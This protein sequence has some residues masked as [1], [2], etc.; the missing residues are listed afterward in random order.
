MDTKFCGTCGTYKTTEGMQE[1][2]AIVTRGSS[3]VIGYRDYVL[4][5]KGHRCADC[6][7]KHRQYVHE[8]IPEGVG[9]RERTPSS[10]DTWGRPRRPQP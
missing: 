2:E 9:V 4:V 5:Q 3:N 7:A 8:P 10:S 6:I 1:F